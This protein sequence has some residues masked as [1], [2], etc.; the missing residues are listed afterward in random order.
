MQ[1]WKYELEVT[2][3]Q[4]VIMPRGAEVLSVQNQGG[5]ICLWVIVDPK[6][7]NVWREFEIIGTGN[8]M[9]PD[10]RRSFIGTVQVDRLVWHV[11]EIG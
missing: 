5:S 9:E 8:P 7:E 4:S 1:I 6:E 10:I 11:F 2:D 3:V